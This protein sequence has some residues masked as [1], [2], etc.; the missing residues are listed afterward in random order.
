[1]KMS[2]IWRLI[3]SRG[4]EGIGFRGLFLEIPSRLDI[5]MT[6][7][8][9]LELLRLHKIRILQETALADISIW[10]NPDEPEGTRT[11]DGDEQGA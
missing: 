6:F 9:V 4:D 7:L 11:P 10:A 5:V 3:R 1:M 8:A 2:E